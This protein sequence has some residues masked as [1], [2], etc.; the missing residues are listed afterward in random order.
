MEN[1]NF[2]DTRPTIEKHMLADG[3]EQV[4]DLHNSHGSWMVDG[5]NG[6]EYLD[7]FSMFASMSIGYNHP[8]VLD[9]TDRLT[10]AAINKP[11]NSD[12]YSPYMAELVQMLERVAQ[13][14]YLPYT[15][16]I[17]GGGLAIENALKT[18][19]DWKVR[20]NIE[21]GKGEIGHQI[22]HFN[23]CFHGRTGYT[24]SLTDSPDTRKVKY[25]PKFDWPRISNPKIHFPMDEAAVADAEKKAIQ[26]IKNAIVA[27]PDD[28]AALIIEPIQGEGGDNH[29]RNEFFQVLRTLADENE[30]LLIYDEVQTGVGI[31]GKMWAH[32]LFDSSEPDIIS[33]GKKTQVCGIFASSR[34]DEVDNHV[35]KESSRLNS[36]WG[37]NLVDMVRFTIYLEVI[38]Q[39]N[40][41]QKAADNGKY[42][43][44]HL[45]RLEAD[46]QGLVSNFRGQGLFCAFDLPN[47]DKRDSLIKL[48]AEE[49]ALMLGSGHKSI[50]FRPH[51]NIN[52]N[53]IDT[54]ISMIRKALGRL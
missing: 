40:L 21:K 8:Y 38:E 43:Q 49:G 9:N 33:F 5:R 31:T 17:E 35:F 10:A 51:L 24:M 20:K 7:L 46:H 28:V 50:R 26:E 4:I 15:F 1:I 22:I 37:G 45:Q 34:L 47:D 25:F 12:I 2:Q 11:T 48:I 54:G 41:V 29:F 32:Q 16:F 36:T 53:E 30:F 27:H 6:K 13:P 23:E 3:M 52:Q 14:K 19:F 42:L 44:N 18:A 39:E